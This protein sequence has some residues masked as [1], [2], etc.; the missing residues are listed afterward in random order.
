MS[1]E[2]VVLGLRP[3][4]ADSLFPV[5]ETMVPDETGEHPVRV[6]SNAAG[7]VVSKPRGHSR[8]DVGPIYLS[9]PQARALA[10]ALDAAA[11][12][13][14]AAPPP[15]L[16]PLTA[17][18]RAGVSAVAAMLS[19]EHRRQLHAWAERRWGSPRWATLDR[20]A[21]AFWQFRVEGGRDA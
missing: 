13:D 7:V 1:D 14:P 3:D 17:V 2:I 10:R 8:A 19:S 18:Q 20:I 15:L 9:R 5:T 12:T 11:G 4:R 6:R 16:P 21:T